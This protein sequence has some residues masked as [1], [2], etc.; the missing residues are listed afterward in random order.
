MDR[1]IRFGLRKKWV[2]AIILLSLI[3]YGTSF[4]CLFVL[5]DLFFAQVPPLL[6]T[7]IVLLLGV[8]WMGI[9]GFWASS[10]LV[11]PL[12]RFEDHLMKVAGG[13]LT[14][15]MKNFRTGDEIGS[16][17]S[18]INRMVIDLRGMIRE[19]NAHFQYTDEGIQQ[20]QE[21]LSQA[22]AQSEEIAAT[23]QSI[24]TGVMEGQ[25]AIQSVAEGQAIL[26]QK[27]MEMMQYADK[28]KESAHRMEVELEGVLSR[29]KSLAEGIYQLR[30]QNETAIRFVRSLEEQASEISQITRV[31]GEIAEQTN[32]LALNASIEAARAGEQGRGFAVVA[33]EVRKLADQSAKAV[34]SISDRIEKIEQQVRLVAT[35]I[36]EQVET[37]TEES[38]KAEHTSEVL[39]GMT[40]FIRDTVTSVDEITSL[41]R[42][43]FHEIDRVKKEMEQL[44]SASQEITE[45]EQQLVAVTQEQSSAMQEIAHFTQEL[46]EKTA[47]VRQKLRFFKW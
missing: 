40:Q 22:A 16:L 15:E 5:K 34:M 20:L 7:A 38:K 10:Y 47:A 14:V 13:D 33:E 29:A 17:A 21:T 27:S 36:A 45:N 2:S 35:Q 28:S 23:I 12:K 25:R 26:S 18:A 11:K 24:A 41:I 32:L 39:S 46:T 4:F 19:M 3:T 37:A 43:E 6:F 42:E 1:N 30:N 31:V 44:A 8:L 9:L